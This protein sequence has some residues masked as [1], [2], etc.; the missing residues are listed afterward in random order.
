MWICLSMPLWG[1]PTPA[2]L[3]GMLLFEVAALGPPHW[4]LQ[5]QGMGIM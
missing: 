4:L 3:T 2:C 1:A 5:P